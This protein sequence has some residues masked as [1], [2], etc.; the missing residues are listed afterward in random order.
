MTPCNFHGG[1][2]GA[3]DEKVRERSWDMYA[4]VDMTQQDP[5]QMEATDRR[6]CA[7][8]VGPLG[9]GQRCETG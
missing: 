9:G 8:E 3:G 6:N 7:R 4:M 5:N 1:L 2:G